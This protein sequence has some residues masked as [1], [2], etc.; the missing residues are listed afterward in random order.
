MSYR[1]RT[2]LGDEARE[3]ALRYNSGKPKLSMIDFDAMEP[4]VRVLEYGARKYTVGAV[5]GRD[6]W[7]KGLPVTEILDSALRHIA[8]I[9]RGEDTDPESGMPHV[10]HLQCNAMFLAHTLKHHP[11][12]DDRKKG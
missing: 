6:N 10:G 2:T 11:E 5:S 3:V 12:L 9:L 8:A 7:K 4:M 1:K